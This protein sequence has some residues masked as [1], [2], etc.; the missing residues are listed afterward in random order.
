MF[1]GRPSE[2]EFENCISYTVTR[3]KPFLFVKFDLV[4][5]LHYVVVT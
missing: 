4:T 5:L 2:L 1:R 3:L